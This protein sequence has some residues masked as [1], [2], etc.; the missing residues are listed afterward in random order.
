MSL[1]KI[2]LITLSATVILSCLAMPVFARLAEKKDIDALKR[3]LMQ[4]ILILNVTT[5]DHIRERYGDAVS[6]QHTA[7]GCVYNYGDITLE[8]VKKQMLMQW[9]SSTTQYPMDSKILKEINGQLNKTI[10]IGDTT[11]TDLMDR[12]GMPS[13]KEIDDRN[14]NSST[15]YYGNIKF[16]FKEIAI[17][18]S[19]NGKNLPS[20]HGRS[21][22][23]QHGV[24]IAVPDDE[25]N[26]K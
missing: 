21:S 1:R 15:L 23:S 25:A 11:M 3:H 17:L 14:P 4:Q 20:V 8:F 26:K 24:L 9:E 19:W 12:Y 2:F 5:L 6:I 22:K 18:K 7:N 13:A 16:L 10:L